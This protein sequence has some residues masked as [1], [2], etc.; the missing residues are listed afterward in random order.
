MFMGR[1][2]KWKS[3]PCKLSPLEIN[4]QHFNKYPS[5]NFEPF[6]FPCF[7]SVGKILNWATLWRMCLAL[8]F[9]TVTTESW[10]YFIKVFQIK[11]NVLIFFFL[12]LLEI[13]KW[14]IVGNKW[15]SLYMGRFSCGKRPQTFS[16]CSDVVVL[17]L[18]G[19]VDTSDNPRERLDPL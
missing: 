15:A 17:N 2:Q 8:L 13:W 1:T 9:G 3:V 7:F 6:I 14:A 10:N 16:Y 11:I 4:T 5:I 19:L 18:Y 12:I